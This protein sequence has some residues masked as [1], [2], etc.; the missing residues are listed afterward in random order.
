MTEMAI[1]EMI[2]ARMEKVIKNASETVNPGFLGGYRL[3]KK[4]SIEEFGD[5]RR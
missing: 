3:T 2:E 1:I 4:L 5:E